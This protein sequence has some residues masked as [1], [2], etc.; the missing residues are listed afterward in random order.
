MADGDL[1]PARFGTAFKAFME[2]VTAE[3]QPRTSP[4]LERIQQHL[5]TPSTK[6]PVFAE[7][8]DAFDHPNIQVA[9]DA[10]LAVPGRQADLVGIGA[11][12]KRFSDFGLSDLMSWSGQSM[13][14]PLVEGPVDHV[15]FHLAG[16]RI[17]ACVQLGLYLV[18]DGEKRLVALVTGPTDNGPRQKLRVEIL[19]RRPEDG[20]AFLAELTDAVTRLNVYRGHVI[21]LSPGRFGPGRQT[22]IAFHSLPRITRDDVILP[23]GVLERVERHTIVFAQQAE[24]LRATGRSLKRGL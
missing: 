8:Y 5:G 14:P 21:S 1:D 2:A 18:R 9:L 24:R 6:L 15:N 16:G 19:A 4:L 12:N 3:A 20:Q 23:E 17:L 22:I 7:E 10:I 11:E 13:R